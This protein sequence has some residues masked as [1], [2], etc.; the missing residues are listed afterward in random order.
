MEKS[1][2]HCLG[3][4]PLCLTGKNK[5]AVVPSFVLSEYEVFF[6]K[7]FGIIGMCRRNKNI[8]VFSY[9]RMS[10][11]FVCFLTCDYLQSQW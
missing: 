7:D 6:P 8:R 4:G 9:C 2:K 11:S 3:L 10:M 5:T 1:H